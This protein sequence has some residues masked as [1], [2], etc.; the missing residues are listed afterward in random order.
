MFGNVPPECFILQLHSC[1]FKHFIAWTPRKYS[2][3]FT[4]P[5]FVLCNILYTIHYWIQDWRHLLIEIRSHL[6]LQKQHSTKA[7]HRTK[8]SWLISKSSYIYPKLRFYT[9]YPNID[10]YNLESASFTSWP[11]PVIK[12]TQLS[13]RHLSL[14]S[15]YLSADVG[16]LGLTISSRDRVLSVTWPVVL[17]TLTAAR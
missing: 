8:F 17:Y 10:L 5:R 14:W 13:G 12:A 15:S 6:P 7:I 16:L 4:P 9:V 3:A 1:M 11:C 2:R